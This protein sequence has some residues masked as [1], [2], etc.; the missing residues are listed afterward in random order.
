MP[1]T[2]KSRL[3]STVPL[4]PPPSAGGQPDDEFEMKASTRDK[5]IENIQT[6]LRLLKE[7]K[8]SQ[9]DNDAKR[10]TD[11]WIGFINL[12]IG[13]GEGK[14]EFNRKRVKREENGE[15]SSEADQS[16]E[17][18]PS[19]FISL[20]DKEELINNL[21]RNRG[22]VDQ[23]CD[24]AEKAGEFK[25]ELSKVLSLLQVNRVEDS[26]MEVIYV[27]NEEDIVKTENDDLS[28]GSSRSK[29]FAQDDCVRQVNHLNLISNSFP[30]I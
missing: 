27:E 1:K 26:E 19:V 21:I 2:R 16:D 30:Q 3:S 20:K 18:E 11:M 23:F 22:Y 9:K 28:G 6:F 24:H 17:Q 4:A 15:H 29:W 10:Q 7:S 5:I 14:H 12:L 8:S 25:L 13:L